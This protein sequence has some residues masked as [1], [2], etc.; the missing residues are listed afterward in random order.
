[1]STLMA[2]VFGLS[3]LLADGT[4]APVAE[5]E[6]VARLAE[7]LQDREH[8]RQQSQ[9]A[10]LLVQNRSAE[11]GEVVRRG[12]SQIESVE[13][14]KALAS[15]LRLKRDQ[16]FFDELFSAL[17]AG[18]PEIR[19]EAAE[20]LAVLADHNVVLRLQE[21]AESAATDLTVRQ[22]A[23]AAL[24]HSGSKAAV[25][26]LLD[27]LSNEQKGLRR[28]AVDALTELTGQTCGSDVA[29]WRA[30]WE[31][32]A[33]LSNERWLEE[34][35][36]YQGSRACR[37]EG[38]LER[39][40]AQIVRLHQQL[41]SRLP[42]ADRLGHV[43]A[44]AEHED[45]AVRGLAAAWSIELL[46]AT[47]ALGQ[48]ALGEVLLRLSRDSAVEVQRQA[49]LALGRVQDP[50][51]F[52]RLRVLIRR[53]QPPVRAAAARSLAEQ[54]K[55]STAGSLEEAR[56]LQRQVVPV[57]QK[58][59]EDPALEVVVEAAEDLGN[60]GLPEA[61]PVLTALLRHPFEPVRQTAAQALERVADASVLEELLT[62]LDDAAVTVR[63]SLVGAVGHAAGD[64]R[65]LSEA[66]RAR[67]LAR[68]EKLLLH[69]TDPGVRS[70]AARVLGDCGPPSLLPTLW[71]RLQASE[72]SRVQE[73]A[74]AA[75]I[76]ILVRTGNMDLLNQWL[77]TL[78]E[79]KQD[80]RRLQLLESAL[81]A[82]KKNPQTRTLVAPATEGMVQVQLEQGKWSAAFPLVRELLSLPG[83]D[84][85]FVNRLRWLLTVGQQS[86]K[87]GNRQEALRVVQEAQPFLPRGR[88]LAADFDKLEKQAQL[89]P[90]P[91][92]PGH[93]GKTP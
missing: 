4:R 83:S 82:W 50:R 86:L 48:K 25:V 38:E 9:A 24:G 69:D 7:M 42:P 60:L 78:A 13:V 57:L 68:L 61:V 29:R 45:P 70:R 77:R 32:R 46:P 72:E 63:F 22:A 11:A 41:Y 65:T 35:L 84:A 5:H 19:Q 43:Q 62:G 17:S 27:L 74:W 85:D 14:F 26:A 53:G 6:D 79:S 89:P 67:L 20:S 49:V 23:V 15:A 44:L 31:G 52:A 1:M 64:G 59:L 10:L 47:D 80:A 71:Q 75:I 58:A 3:F 76:N 92:L 16:R 55:I 93:D 28:S 66:M 34:R 73:K 8:P 40:K 81:E 12:L 18:R 2:L 21:L 36:Y 56:G 90:K 51:V 37:V 30:W 91:P 33:C 39:A 88:H 54:A 87:E